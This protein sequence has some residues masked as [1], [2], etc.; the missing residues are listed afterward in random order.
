MTP[1]L[2][3]LL[4]SACV[5]DDAESLARASTSWHPLALKTRPIRFE[6]VV[7]PGS[8]ERA[9]ATIEFC[10][11]QGWSVA[12]VGGGSGTGEPP[13]AKIGLDLSALNS[14]A[15]NET[16]LAVTAGA[17][18]TIEALETDL[19]RHGYT[20]GQQIGS[21]NLATV[22]GCVAT[23]AVGLF[24]GR[25][26]GFADLVRSVESVENFVLSAQLSIRPAPEARAWAVFESKSD[27]D[28]L[29]ALRLVY[30]S[31]ARP[32]L[33][34]YCPLAPNNR[35]KLLMAFEGDEIVQ[36][37]HYQLAFAVCQQ[38]GLT[39]RDSDEGEAWLEETSRDTLWSQ[40][41]RE[42]V[43]ADRVSLALSWSRLPDALREARQI[44]ERPGV[45]PHLD[46]RNPGPH[47]ATL[48]M[49]FVAETDERGWRR[50]REELNEIGE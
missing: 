20:L 3:A 10:A 8:V 25:Y 49:G 17:G 40:N 14:V 7:R 18:V 2:S 45:T 46:V 42:G 37:G 33:A 19:N 15:L 38:V 44:L 26:G 48:A 13:V 1:E 36:A 30:R 24:S 43:W 35:G 39:P 34:R 28:A 4:G 11:E 6:I 16:D 50:L 29:D 41:A 31:D 23:K 5:F 21:S 32:S 22:G 9:R 27:T 12:A 47:G